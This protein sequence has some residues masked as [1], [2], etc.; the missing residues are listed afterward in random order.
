MPDIT[1]TS[2]G[3]VFLIVIGDL[4]PIHDP[5][6][7]CDLVRPHDHQHILGS[8]DAVFGQDVQDRMLCKDL[9]KLHIDYKTIMSKQI[10]IEDDLL[11]ELLFVLEFTDMLTKLRQYGAEISCSIGNPSGSDKW[12]VHIGKTL[13]KIKLDYDAPMFADSEGVWERTLAVFGVNVRMNKQ[14]MWEKI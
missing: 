13:T 2:H 8:E 14:V 10:G 12:T 5:L 3:A 1:A 7:C 6:S 4:D 9:K 11:N